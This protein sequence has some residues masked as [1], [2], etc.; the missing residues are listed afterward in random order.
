M[1]L[2]THE[3]SSSPSSAVCTTMTSDRGPSPAAVYASTQT[4]YSVHSCRPRTMYDNSSA[5]T[6]ATLPSLLPPSASAYS[7]RYP[8]STPFHWSASGADHDTRMLWE[9]TVSPLTDN[10]AAPGA[11][12]QQVKQRNSR[13]YAQTTTPHNFTFNNYMPTF[14]HI[15]GVHSGEDPRINSHHERKGKERKSIYIAPF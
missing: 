10:G 6:V 7:T 4:L 15:T 14:W 9:S 3:V 12:H 2:S 13:Q 8:A 1:S 5:G 11:T